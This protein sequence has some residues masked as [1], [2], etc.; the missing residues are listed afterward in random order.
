MG[1][2]RQRGKEGPYGGLFC[3]REKHGVGIG[4]RRCGHSVKIERTL[5]GSAPQFVESGTEPDE[6]LNEGPTPMSGSTPC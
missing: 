2:S 6:P 1:E 5:R 4:P 3:A